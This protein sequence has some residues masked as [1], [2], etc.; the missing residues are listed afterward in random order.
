MEEKGITKDRVFE[1]LRNYK[2]RDMTHRSGRILG[3]MCTCPHEVGLKA[4]HMFLESNLGDPGLFQGTKTMENEVIATLGQLL[5]KNNVYGHVIT[6]GT[7]A[8]IMAMRAAR[9]MRRI[10]DPEIIVPKSAHFSF[11]KAADILCLKMREAQLDSQY[12]VDINSV[13][14]LISDKTVAVVG[15]AGTTELGKI[16]PIEELSDI[17]LEREIFLH[18]DAAFGGFSIPFLNQVGYDLPKFDFSLPG[19]C[20][21][22]I[23]PHKMGLAPIPTGGILFRDKSYLD[24]MSVETP[25]LTEENQSTIVGTRTGAS[26][27][28][29]WALLK[30]LGSEGYQKIASRCMELTKLL[31]QGIK[32]TGFQLIT[33]PQL[34]IVAFTGEGIAP[35]DIAKLLDEKG[36]AVSIA[37]HPKSVRIIVM[38]HVK[39]E[40]IR[41]F[42]EDLKDIRY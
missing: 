21:V 35:C 23:D 2:K 29:T 39:E 17:C 38:P 25:Y 40:H 36:W 16:D 37:S 27:A 12:R 31:A 41:A 5:G 32:D 22:T 24:V 18:V 8:N 7:E 11:K 30:H 9:N 28:A 6:G 13:K 34:N 19:V 20:S 10:K 4:Y 33:E 15:I 3:S 1:L 42:L 14:E 26:T